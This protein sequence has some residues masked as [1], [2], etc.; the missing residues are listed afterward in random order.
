M[1]YFMT[2]LF[3]TALWGQTLNCPQE[4]FLIEYISPINNGKISL[5]GYIKDGATVKHGEEWNYNTKGELVKKLNFIHGEEVKAG[6]NLPGVEEKKD[7]SK[8]TAVMESIGQMLQILTLK[9]ANPG[10]G[11]FK[12]QRCD[13]KP[14]DWVQG[15]VML[16]PINKTYSFAEKCDVAG[17]FTANFKT[18]F[19]VKFNLR[20]L[21]DYTSTEMMV[22]MEIKKSAG[23][24]TYGFDVVSGAISS[25]TSSAQFTVRYEVEIN[26]MTGATLAGSQKG[27]VSL[28]KLDGKD[29]KA[30]SPILFEE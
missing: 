2:I 21:Q 23:G 17:T 8:E 28:T 7:L 3:T 26:P 27:T 9:K 20:N 1:K 29:V 19:P 13:P 16:T 15:A 14:I 10:K 12:I 18:E 25:Q 11:M 5:C 24:I 30:S 22:R 6:T 4:S